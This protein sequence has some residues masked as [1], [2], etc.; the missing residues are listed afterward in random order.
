[1]LLTVDIGNTNIVLGLFENDKL[2]HKWRIATQKQLTE[3]EYANKLLPL[4][5]YAEIDY[6]KINGAIISSVVNKITKP[7]AIFVEKYLKLSSII[8]SEVEHDININI[9]VGTKLGSDILAN[10]IASNRMY[11]ENCIF[12]DFGTALVIGIIKKE[13]EFIGGL[14]LPGLQ[15]SFN[16]LIKSTDRLFYTHL[17]KPDNIVGENTEDCLRSGMFYLYKES[18]NGIINKIKKELDIDFKVIVT[19]GNAILIQGEIKNIDV[20]EPNLTLEGLN[21]LYK[22]HKNK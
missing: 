9:D 19:G 5:N 18:I 7:M 17:L 14:I 13:K 11:N 15:T 21:I 8:A 2:I 10:A 4:F 22:M 3:D 6:T 12:I 20:F 16:S 1:M